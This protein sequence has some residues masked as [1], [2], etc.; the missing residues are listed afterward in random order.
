[1]AGKYISTAK[2]A[3]A[4]NIASR[5]ARDLIEGDVEDASFSRAVFL[6]MIFPKVVI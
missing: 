4:V 3:T 6:S 5:T 2:G 1:M